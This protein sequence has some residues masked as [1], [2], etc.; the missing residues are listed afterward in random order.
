[1]VTLI[2]LENQEKAL[3]EEKGVATEQPTMNTDPS[4]TGNALV[5]VV[6]QIHQSQVS[7][8]F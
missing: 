7:T 5:L 8:L 6:L 4:G 2:L 3:R 1:M